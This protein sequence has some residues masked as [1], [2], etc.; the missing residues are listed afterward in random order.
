MASSLENGPFL[1]L[2]PA[3]VLVFCIWRFKPSSPTYHSLIAPKTRPQ[4]RF[5]SFLEYTKW[6]Y[7][8]RDLFERH[9][10]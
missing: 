4:C 10:L 2:N 5:F 6:H 8:K 9:S 1:Y 7:Q 3:I